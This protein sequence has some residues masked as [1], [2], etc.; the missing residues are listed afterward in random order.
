MP[1]PAVISEPYSGLKRLSSA[2]IAATPLEKL[3]KGHVLEAESILSGPAPIAALEV[4]LSEPATRSALQRQGIVYRD[5]LDL[6]SKVC[7]LATESLE[8][9]IGRSG[10]LRGADE[11]RIIERRYVQQLLAQVLWE[12]ELAVNSGGA[13]AA[14]HVPE[15]ANGMET[16]LRSQSA[17]ETAAT[18]AEIAS[19]C[20]AS[21]RESRLPSSPAAGRSFGCRSSGPLSDG[22]ELSPRRP[23]DVV[24]ATVGPV[25][26]TTTPPPKPSRRPPT[27]LADMKMRQQA[28][29][30]RAKL[31]VQ[32]QEKVLQNNWSNKEKLLKENERLRS[33][34][35]D[36]IRAKSQERN[37]HVECLR[38]SYNEREKQRED[39]LHEEKAKLCRRVEDRVARAKAMSRVT[40]ELAGSATAMRNAVL[41]SNRRQINDR[42]AEEQ[43]AKAMRK[44]KAQESAD[45]RRRAE[46]RERS[47]GPPGLRAVRDLSQKQAVRM[48]RIRTQ[49]REALRE[50][51][52]RCPSAGLHTTC[53][54]RSPSRPSSA[55]RYVQSNFEVPSSPVLQ[56]RSASA[57]R[58]ST[59]SERPHDMVQADPGTAKSDKSVGSP[60]EICNKLT[61]TNAAVV[62]EGAGSDA[63]RASRQVDLLADS[64][65]DIV[66]TVDDCSQADGRSEA[67][68]ASSPRTCDVPW[69]M[70]GSQAEHASA[71]HGPV[72]LHDRAVV[73]VEPT[74][75]AVLAANLVAQG[76]ACPVESL[77]AVTEHDA[78]LLP[79]ELQNAL[80]EEQCTSASISHVLPKAAE[81][82]EHMEGIAT[83]AASGTEVVRVALKDSA[84]WCCS[85]DVTCK[86]AGKVLA[87]SENGDKD[88]RVANDELCIAKYVKRR[89]SL[90]ACRSES[91][92]KPG[93]EVM[94]SNE[95]DLSVKSC[96]LA[97][98]VRFSPFPRNELAATSLEHAQESRANT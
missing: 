84:T 54:P 16:S 91:R 5:V 4:F 51:L 47:S 80:C 68:F 73:S 45:A 71:F 7:T 10:G 36:R 96:Q 88:V 8:C 27:T 22:E 49:Q 60:S 14:V 41:E 59:A 63:C 90:A 76:P 31:I 43:L 52:E 25:P 40:A 57:S 82:E 67:L 94:A 58:P 87:C 53:Y 21:V 66:V 20:S 19:G 2:E 37:H 69:P 18:A 75:P 26:P 83:A 33:Q 92:S 32:T 74:Q 78:T 30:E 1:R 9:S 48:E 62:D 15:A 17:V 56:H 3:P 98:S 86:S 50:R 35:L 93:L 72:A 64:K 89:T 12:R 61:S 70:L 39:E 46:L 38:A 79:A 55:R 28:S 44:Q 85:K 95:A 42:A 23:S 34:H 24:E 65:T 13:T 97:S 81:Y 11:A 29:R 77:R 6:S